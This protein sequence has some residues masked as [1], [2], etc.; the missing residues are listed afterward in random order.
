MDCIQRSSSKFLLMIALIW[1]FNLASVKDFRTSD[2]FAISMYLKQL[3]DNLRSCLNTAIFYA[4]LKNCTVRIQEIL[5]LPESA[6]FT[7]ENEAFSV[8]DNKN[9]PEI[10]I[11]EKTY[12]ISDI[13][14]RS[15]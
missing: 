6:Q 8:D 14:G 4:E 7:I 5:I 3:E 9:N 12:K 2:L 15:Q 11:L 1:Y 10:Q 13:T